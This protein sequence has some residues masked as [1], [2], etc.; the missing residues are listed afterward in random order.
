MYCIRQPYLTLVYAT[1]SYEETKMGAL[2]EALLNLSI[3]I[4]LLQVIGIEGVII[5]TL[6]ANIFRT[7]QFAIFISKH[8]LHRSV[9]V[10]VKRFA[11]VVGCIVTIGIVS[12]T[13]E[14]VI[15][16][17]V[18]WIGWLEHAIIVFI[19]SLIITVLA[20]LL[21]YKNDFM[22]LVNTFFKTFKR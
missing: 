18:S 21:C 19:I 8:I 22:D 16:F 4:I 1:G 20:S 12:L 2:V 11:W 10:V 14:N 15:I 13:L 3:S 7:I 9:L 17:S 5:G 6:V